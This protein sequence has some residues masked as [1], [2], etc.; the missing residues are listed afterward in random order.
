TIT[1]HPLFASPRHVTIT[2]N[3]WF[4]SPKHITTTPYPC[5]VVSL[6]D[7]QEHRAGHRNTWL[8]EGVSG[9]RIRHDLPDTCVT[10]ATASTTHT[11]A[12]SSTRVITT[13]HTTQ[14]SRLL[15]LQI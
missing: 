12:A 6:E 11:L 1:P 14:L 5:F 2:P 13:T 7:T 10:T 8:V 4:V 15:S 3:S 9:P